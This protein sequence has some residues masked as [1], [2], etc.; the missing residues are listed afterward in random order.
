M[1]SFIRKDTK[2]LRSQIRI[3]LQ[4]NFLYNISAPSGNNGTSSTM[5]AR[6]RMF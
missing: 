4:F 5:R 6:N 1:V 2:V 3:K